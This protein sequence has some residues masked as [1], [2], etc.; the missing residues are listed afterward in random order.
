MINEPDEQPESRAPEWA[1][2]TVT[3]NSASKLAE[4]WGD[5]PLNDNVEWIVVD[6]ASQ[7]DSVEV[8]RSLGARVVPLDRNRG[9]GGANNVGFEASA[10]PF[11]AFVNPDITV[12]LGSL[13]RLRELIERTGAIVSPQLLYPD[14]RPQP[15][16]RGYP[17]LANKVLNRVEAED[18]PSDYRRFAPPGADID[19]VWFMGAA[20]L[21]SRTTFDA[22]GPWDER[23][24]VYYED[25]DLGLRAARRGIR[26]IVS[27]HARWVHGWA[28]ETT[29]L[30]LAAW[31]RELPS[32][33]KFYSRYPRLL[34]PW[35]TRSARN[36]S[37]KGWPRR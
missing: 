5:L 10:A 9:F 26:R 27:G 22:L 37:E 14:G 11:V 25:S 31:R 15:N 16:G 21:G 7:D 13:D 6:N 28:R 4:F 29:T 1:L 19:V 2:I 24:F 12:N 20:V 18:R 36:L 30:D 35:P 8:A 32:M 3:Y 23:F 33:M 34:S 17:F